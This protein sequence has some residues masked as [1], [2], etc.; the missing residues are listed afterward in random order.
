LGEVRDVQEAVVV[1]EEV[2]VGEV[3][4]MKNLAIQMP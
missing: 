1:E 3:M 2:E 4:Q